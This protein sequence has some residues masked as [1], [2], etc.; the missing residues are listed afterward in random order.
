MR[1][2]AL[3]PSP[4]KSPV[5]ATIQAVGTLPRRPADNT[6]A[7]FISQIAVLPV[8][9]RDFAPPHA[10]RPQSRA[11]GSVADAGLR[12]CGATPLSTERARPAAGSG[13]GRA[14]APEFG[15]QSAGVDRRARRHSQAQP[16]GLS[17]CPRLR[18]NCVRWR[19]ISARRRAASTCARMPAGSTVTRRT[20]HRSS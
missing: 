12:W 6:A 2:C 7:P 11:A 8:A 13:H 15:C 17:G 5:S 20:G 1:Q 18:P 14:D 19:K 9:C 4:S 10:V 3:L 16:A